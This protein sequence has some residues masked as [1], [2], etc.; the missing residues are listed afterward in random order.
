MPLKDDLLRKG[1]L[2]ENLPPGFASEQIAD[3]FI[4][5]PRQG[6]LSQNARPV[7]PAIYNAS[8]RGMSRRTF[9]AIHPTT[10][11]DLAEFI[12]ARWDEL[13]TFFKKSSFSLSVPTLTPDG[14]RALGITSH[15]ELEATKLARLSHYRF[16]AKTDISRFYHSIYTHSIPWALHGRKEAKADRDVA[17]AKVFCNRADQIL[18]CG[19]DG[20][21]IGIPVGPDASRMIAETICTAIDLEFSNRCT[22]PDYSLLRHVDDIWIGANSHADVEN[23]L[24][25][26][27]E[28]IR[29]FELDINE[30]KTK[31][32]AEDF[33]FCDRWPTDIA[34]QLEFA[35][36][37]PQHRIPERLRAALEHAFSFATTDG[38]DGVLKYVIRYIDQTDLKEKHWESVEP[39]LRRS[40]TH[41][42]HTV[43]YVT[44]VLVWRHLVHDDLNR[45]AWAA[46][47]QAI[48]DRQGRLGNDS[49]VC[50]AIY[51]CMRLSISIPNGLA[52]NIFSN[53]GAMS[54]LT[55]LNCIELNL[56]DGAVFSAAH[57]RM[58][59][60]SASGPF[61]PV[62]M[63][64]VSRRWPNF[65]KLPMENEVV[66]DLANKEVLLFQ[67]GL[68]PRVFRNLQ[69]TEFATVAQAIE[70][71]VSFYEDED[72]DEDEEATLF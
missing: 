50:W 63:E 31:I 23:A 69:Q 2:P 32:Y 29:E 21:T 13:Q 72:E 39:F 20:Q 28:A 37:S 42:G 10:G 19:Q 38:D 60:E 9:S 47:L 27:R 62:M 8:K 43:D 51:A 66:T 5:N 57:E 56:V 17:S 11:H 33:R 55:L 64:W 70:H 4:K 34:S 14:D 15:N 1:Y 16:I 44:R 59:Q 25:R 71:R 68:L 40:A 45:N 24:W 65:R 67:P 53:C 61:W 6:F 58:S 22:V 12:S 18:R 3:Y 7:R 36:N 48:L 54:F 30:N 41:F 35:I 49:E 46:I 26:Y 52:L